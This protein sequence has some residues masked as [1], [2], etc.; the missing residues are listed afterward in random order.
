MQ[1]RM[2]ASTGRMGRFQTEWPATDENLAASTKLSEIWIDRDHDRKK[3]KVMRLIDC[4]EL[5]PLPP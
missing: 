3:P 1:G 5:A 2:A 4:L